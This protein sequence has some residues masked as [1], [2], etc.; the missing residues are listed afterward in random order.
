MLQ[1]GKPVFGSTSKRWMI[2]AGVGAVDA[3]GQYIG[4][5]TIGFNIV[6][7]LQISYQINIR[8]NIWLYFVI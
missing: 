8:Q 3:S 5:M 7:M 1:F 6:K 4:A 2:P